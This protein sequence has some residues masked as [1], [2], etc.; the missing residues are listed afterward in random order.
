MVSMVEKGGRLLALALFAFLI[1]EV[2][3][4]ASRF[5]VGR[6]AV[7]TYTEDDGKR[8]MPSISVCFDYKM[9]DHQG[10]D[11][12][13]LVQKTLNEAIFHYKYLEVNL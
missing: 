9:V 11:I 8:I 6:T 3:T 13:K 2:I 7:T 10:H 12:G 4:S 1:Y 5:W